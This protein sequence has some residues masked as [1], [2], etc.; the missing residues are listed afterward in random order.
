MARIASF[1]LNNLFDR[2]NFAASVDELPQTGGTATYE[3]SVDRSG[4]DPG[5]MLKRSVKFQVGPDGGLISPKSTESL[6]ALAARI[7]GCDAELVAVQEV[8]NLDALS[9][10]NSEELDG[11]YDYVVLMEGNDPRFID[12]GLLSK[13]PVGRVS[14]HRF[15]PD[16]DPRPGSNGL[17]FGR[18]CL[19]VEVLNGDRSRFM[20]V[21]LCHL[22]SNYVSWRVKDPTE[23]AERVA[24]NHARRSRQCEG[25]RAIVQQA[26]DRGEECLVVGDMNAAPDHFSLAPLVQDPTLGLV[27][28]LQMTTETNPPPA[29]RNPEDTPPSS[30]WSYRHSESNAP[31]VFTL[32]DQ[33]WATPALAV[34]THDARIG[35]RTSWRKDANGTDHDPVW[36]E[37]D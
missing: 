17:L 7:L 27:D 9:R 25:T 20:T 2:F 23:R 8:E 28:L 10:F 4:A 37:V 31:D 22:K 15:M 32:F 26:V 14:S 5:G 13:L 30:P 33:M 18:D 36:V 1:N 19:E 6:L 35:R 21:F 34:R 16:P 12:V 11:L 29:A 3:W 24:G